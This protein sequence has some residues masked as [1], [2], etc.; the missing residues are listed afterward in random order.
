MHSQKILAACRKELILW[1]IS[2]KKYEKLLNHNKVIDSICY[3]H[4]YKNIISCSYNN[5]YIWN[6]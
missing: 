4:D 3:S 5:I 6:T 1:D 2:S